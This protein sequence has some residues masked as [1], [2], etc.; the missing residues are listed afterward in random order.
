MRI[1][2]ET[3]RATLLLV[4]AAVLWSLAG[5]FIKVIDWNPPAIA[6]VRSLLALP[7]LWAYV[8]RHGGVRWG[9]SH[10][11]GGMAYCAVVIMFAMATRMTT[12][13][14]AI[15]LQYTAPIYVA[16][17]SVWFLKEKVRTRDWVAIGAAL[18]GMALFFFDKLT[19]SGFWGN[20]IAL[21]SGVAFAGL[22]LIMRR[23]KDSTPIG[24]LLV[25]N[26][27]TGVVCLPFMFQAP[28]QAVG[29]WLLLV[30]LGVFQL[31]LSYLCFAVAISHVPAVRA[32]TI[33]TL[34]PI[35]NPLWVFLFI[36]ERPGTWALPGGA[37]VLG[38]VLVRAVMASREKPEP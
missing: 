9:W 16:L 24:S 21:V 23:Q 12:A 13:A 27:L 1:K 25:G 20:V 6:G 32:I 37:I 15:M 5:V 26:I 33:T 17:F 19:V 11:A 22:T 35:L 36:G 14:N 2:R 8:R 38:S 4:A 34:E 10:V 31:G 3:T 28:P 18:F 7:L 29:D 30:V